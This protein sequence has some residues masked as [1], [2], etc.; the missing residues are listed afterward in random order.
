MEKIKIAK[1]VNSVGL[2]GEVKLY[3]Y[4]D[5]GERYKDID[6]IILMKGST[7]LKKKIKNVRFSGAMVILKLEGTDDRN[8]ADALRDFD[9][10][11]TEGDLRELPEDE[12]YIRDLVGLEVIDTGRYGKIGVLSDVIQN[13]A[14][15][16]YV[17]TTNDGREIMIPAVREFI[18]EV[19]IENGIIKTKLIQGFID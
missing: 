13:S 15:D 11:I 18:E 2:K 8:A 7:E 14:Q 16:V 19:D 17:I 1:I 3:N 10:F 4:S 6:E 12:F 5:S 9:V